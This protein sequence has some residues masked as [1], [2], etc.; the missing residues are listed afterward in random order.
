MHI[1]ERTA[2]PTKLNE[3]RSPEGAVYCF[4]AGVWRGAEGLI[5]YD[6]RH[7]KATKKNDVET[8]ED[9]KGQ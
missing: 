3:E 7:G 8:G 1:L 4:E 5:T 9:Q 2:K 6:P